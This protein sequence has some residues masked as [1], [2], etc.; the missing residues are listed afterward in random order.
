[1]LEKPQAEAIAQQLIDAWNS[2]DIVAIMSR[3]R[4]DVEVTSPMFLRILGIPDGT[5]RGRE[6]LRP[7]WLKLLAQLPHLRFKLH[8][9]YV[10]VDGFSMHMQ[11][12]FERDSVVMVRVDEQGLIRRMDNFLVNLELP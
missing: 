1:M 11:S 12:L 7:F 10:G 3:Y 4:E 6:S 2:R 5:L 8:E 9:V